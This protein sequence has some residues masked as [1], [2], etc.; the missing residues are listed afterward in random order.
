MT[1]LYIIFALI[2]LFMIFFS[3]F[4]W[5]KLTNN[6]FID[7]AIVKKRQMYK[8]ITVIGIL[9]FAA[10]IELYMTTVEG[11]SGSGFLI[12]I[13][14]IFGYNR[15][16]FEPY[17]NSS[18]VEDIDDLCL[19]LRPF[20]SDT[21]TGFKSKG[22]I[23]GSF[24]F[25]EPIEKYLCKFLHKRIAQ[26]F[27]IGN[28]GSCVPTTLSTTCIYASDDEWK[29][30]I[31]ILADKAK[32]IIV[33]VGQTE[34]CKWEIDH[35]IQQKHLNKIIFLVEDHNDMNF[36][37]E[38]MGF[39]NSI[40]ISDNINNGC[41]LIFFSQT[42]QKWEI[43]KITNRKDVNRAV[44]EFIGQNFSLMTD[45]KE[46]KNR[47]NVIS[48]YDNDNRTPAKGWQIV[49]LMTNPVACFL[50][51][52]WPVRWIVLLIVYYIIGLII[53][54]WAVI[55]F[56]EEPI[57]YGFI[58]WKLLLAFIA[59][60]AIISIPWL[61]IAPRISWRIPNW[62]SRR[63]FAKSNRSLAIWLLVY[64]ASSMA[65]SST[66][67][68]SYSDDNDIMQAQI[69]LEKALE[70]DEKGNYEES[71]DYIVESVKTFQN[72]INTTALAD[73]YF[74]G[75]GTPQDFHTAESYYQIVADT[76][77][78]DD[79]EDEAKIIVGYACAQFVTCKLMQEQNDEQL[80]E[81]YYDKALQLGYDMD[82][83]MT[84][85]ADEYLSETDNLSEDE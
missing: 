42:T 5:R 47:K 74:Y 14:M 8:N 25:S 28:P 80:F 59:F 23:K 2:G 13:G 83:H 43:R 22:T 34:G 39:L 77:V 79:F 70:L 38:R 12:V 58:D 21:K 37:R 50:F 11:Q 55:Q 15:M 41:K 30:T 29:Q 46:K 16:F 65:I 63:V 48:K 57:L 64:S 82:G 44:E 10:A 78:E 26:P 75:N 27:A 1:A 61:W 33:R 17:F 36:L 81:K 4:T 52:K 7:D 66:A 56:W 49:S 54:V 76:E 71:F 20:N 68:T 31:A 40:D 32:T 24:G 35:C 45:L 9:I 73:C 62:G 3:Y 19:Y 85:F 6:T 72:V 53:F 84:S 51:N 67:F 60:F 69:L 18:I